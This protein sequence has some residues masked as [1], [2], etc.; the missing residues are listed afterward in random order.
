MKLKFSILSKVKD[1]MT[2]TRLFVLAAVFY[3]AGVNTNS[4]WLCILACLIAGLLIFSCACL[5]SA[6]RAN[7]IFSIN[8]IQGREG[9]EIAAEAVIICQDATAWCSACIEYIFPEGLASEDRLFLKRFSQEEYS[10]QIKIKLQKRGIYNIY[11]LKLK[12]S[13]PLGLIHCYKTFYLPAEIIVQPRSQA[14]R[15]NSASLTRTGENASIERGRS[16][17][18]RNIREYIDGEDTRFIH[19][20]SSA[21]LGTLMIREFTKESLANLFIVIENDALGISEPSA[22]EK[23]ISN[24][25]YLIEQNTRMKGKIKIACALPSFEKE[26]AVEGIFHSPLPKTAQTLEKLIGNNKKYGKQSLF[27]HQK[28]EKLF[29]SF[30]AQLSR[31]N[32]KENDLIHITLNENS[33]WAINSDITELTSFI[34]PVAPMAETEWQKIAESIPADYQTAILTLHPY[35]RSLQ[36]MKGARRKTRAISFF[37]PIAVQ[38]K[39]PAAPQRRYMHHPQNSAAFAPLNKA[40]QSAPSHGTGTDNID[41]LLM[42]GSHDR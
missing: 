18:L 4:G 29:K 3:V 2:A 40:P 38:P 28:S 12:L 24:V 11:G 30:Y 26:Q 10:A 33:P 27:L 32:I 7:G 31:I 34:T 41:N 1:Y 35:S 17:D 25:S 16:T 21:K 36:F 14:L 20:A 39:N 5:L 19:W 8:S 42:G 23:L 22:L 13:D 15:L 37:E 6:S 9:Q